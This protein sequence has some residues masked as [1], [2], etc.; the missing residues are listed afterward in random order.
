MIVLI[1]CAYF[2]FFSLLFFVLKGNREQ[3]LLALIFVNILFYINVTLIQKPELTPFQLLPYIFFAREICFNYS[4]FKKAL[5]SFPVKTGMVIIFAAYFLTTYMNGGGGHSYYEAF[6]Y[7]FDKYIPMIA[8]FICAKDVD[9]QKL[10]KHLFLFFLV[11]CCFGIIE[12]LLNHNYVREAIATAFPSTRVTDMYGPAGVTNGFGGSSWRSRISITTKHPTTLG[13]LLFTMFLFTLSYFK[14]AK[15][16]FGVKKVKFV[17]FILAITTVLSGS[18]TAMCCALL[19]VLIFFTV[20]LSIRKRIVALIIYG[21]IA[22]Q[23][24]S[25]ALA[26]FEEKENG[27]SVALRQ[28]QLLFTL[29]EFADKPLFG[30]GLYFTNHTILANDNDGKRMY[31]SKDETEGMESIVFYTL[32][33]IGLFGAFALVVFYGQT[34]IFFFR[35]RKRDDHLPIQGMLET[36]L[37]VVFLILSGE[38]GRN[39]EMCLLF[40]GTSL[41]LLQKSIENEN[42]LP[43]KSSNAESV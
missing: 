5:F 39:T 9:E 42:S 14:V 16:Q 6:R 29:I 41:G 7:C 13:T 28:Q 37:L 38:I 22:I 35:R 27:S 11:F 20:R 8:V 4:K 24:S 21:V 3:Q 17:L 23:A 19:G 25:F 40:I 31:Y 18:R 12:F 30:H 10:I 1:L 34:F 26:S 15:E 33:D 32:L 2:V 43:E 36:F